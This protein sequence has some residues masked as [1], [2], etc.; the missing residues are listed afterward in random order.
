MDKLRTKIH[1]TFDLLL[2]SSNLTSREFRQ[3]MRSPRVSRR[4]PDWSVAISRGQVIGN[5]VVTKISPKMYSRSL[6]E[7]KK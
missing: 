3:H 5:S 1:G 2:K 4:V 7:V 6:S